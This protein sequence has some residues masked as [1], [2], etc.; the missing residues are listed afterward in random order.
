[1]TDIQ[2]EILPEVNKIYKSQFKFVIE[3]FLTKINTMSCLEIDIPGLAT[4]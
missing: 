4:W 1:M 3:N 2:H